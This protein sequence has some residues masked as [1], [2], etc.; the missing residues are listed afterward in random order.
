MEIG[1]LGPLQVELDGKTSV[2]SAPKL[3]TVLVTLAVQANQVVPVSTLI[4]ELWDDEPPMSALTTLQ[5]YI[6]N[7]RKLFT[8]A[9]GFS[10]R[11]VAEE[12]L[13][14][15]TG[16]Y[17][18]RIDALHV[19]ASRHQELVG[20]GNVAVAKQ[21]HHLG[22]RY[23]ED[24]VRLWRGS[25]L[26]DVQAGRVLESKRLQFEESRLMA[27]EGLTEARLNIGSYQE[28]MA[29]LVAL[30]AD[31]PL[32][33]GLHSQYMR[34]LHHAGRR[35]QALIVYRR[36]RDNLVDQLGLEPSVA[37][38]DIHRS[39]LQ[40]DGQPPSHTAVSGAGKLHRTA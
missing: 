18:L 23:F 24:A 31:N 2:P 7:L 3:R 40:S 26:V 37:V 14:T 11:E 8:T 28:A 5:T 38:R 32:H 19:D 20:M 29:D 16:G 27:L 10:A 21:D 36:L 13:V 39:I 1:L 12:V 6:L 33:E 9:T 22:M 15:K 35:A 17:Q 25:A 4:R 30:T 34:A